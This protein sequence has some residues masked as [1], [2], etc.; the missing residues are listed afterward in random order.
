MPKLIA[1]ITAPEQLSKALLAAEA[2]KQAAQKR[3]QTLMV[4]VNG[5]PR[6]TAAEIAEADEILLVGQATDLGRFR[7]SGT[8]LRHL[9]LDFVLQDAES[10]LAIPTAGLSIVAI[11][12]CPV[13]V[14]HTFMAAEGLAEGARR[15]GHRIKVETQGSIGAQNTL[16]PEEIANADLVIIAADTQVDTSRFNG[17][18]IHFASTKRAIA[19]GSELVRLAIEEARPR[20]AAPSRMTQTFAAKAADSAQRTGPY[21]HLMTGVS[22]MLP[23]VVAGGVLIAL[24]FALGGIYAYDDSNKDTLAWALFQ[25]GAKSSFA[26][27]VPILA[28]Y[29]AYSIADRPGLAPGMVGGMLAV[30]L[31]AGF[32]G[33]IIA[34]F[35][36]GYATDWLNR[37]INLHRNLESLKPILL[38]PILGS[39]LVG[40][41]MIYVVGGPIAEALSVLIEW[42][43]HMQGSSALLL[44]ALIGAM[45]AF[46]MGGPVNKAAYTF[47][48]A[49]LASQ[50]YGPMAAAMAAGMTPPLGLALACRLFA[51]RF[52]QEEREAGKAASVLG[53]A[54]ITEGAIP[55]AAR[56]PLRVIPALM[57]GAA[58]T[59][60][61]SMA[62]SVELRVPHG[63]VFILFMPNTVAHLG[64]YIASLA[65]G[66]LATALLLRLLK[67]P[68]P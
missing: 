53:I 39:L 42:L 66:T 60:A 49:L 6:M 2:L 9:E 5:T 13:G 25:I 59:G 62:L 22:H 41:M 28:G 26:L 4:E 37:H 40:L 54:F 19:D 23:F 33:G 52:S 27:M 29:I 56:D 44:G 43:K 17:K 18:R 57:G 21:K 51:N 46:D 68:L 30:S 31:G 45:M 14:A 32:L 34:G 1:V 11:T 24:A 3:G 16:S 8:T 10:A 12:A 61:L 15:L 38:L 64:S 48:T 36:A 67:K 35:L 58:L 7:F 55:F 63:G 50:V 47:A 20:H 65:L